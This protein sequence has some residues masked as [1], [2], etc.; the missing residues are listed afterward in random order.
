MSGCDQGSLSAAK[1]CTVMIVIDALLFIAV[2]FL[3][4]TAFRLGQ[5][6]PKKN[7]RP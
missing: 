3:I 6:Y 1:D 7:K 2:L 5:K 4:Y